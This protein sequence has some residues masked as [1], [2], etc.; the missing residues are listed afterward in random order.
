MPTE[1]TSSEALFAAIRAGEAERVE[2]LVTE[3]PELLRASGPD[4]ISP[5]MTALYFGQSAVAQLLQARVPPDGLSI[6]EAAATGS[7]PRLEQ[8]LAADPGS[9]NAWSPDGFQ[10][11]GLAAFFGQAAAVDLLLARGAEVN[12]KARHRFGVTA[13]HAALAGPAPEIAR[14]LIGAGAEVNAAQ[15]SGET[16]LHETA[17]RGSVELTRLLLQHGA[18]PGAKDEQGRTA[19]DVA[20]ERGHSEVAELLGSG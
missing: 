19:A 14:T 18:D 6:H 15:N 17:F 10:P 9:V 12:T 11:L 5:L 20:R 4:G 13:L 2:Q 7:L 3:Q 16:P 8:L 1:T